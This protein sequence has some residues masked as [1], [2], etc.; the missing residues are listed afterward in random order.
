MTSVSIC[1]D[2]MRMFIFRILGL[3]DGR[4]R[5][6]CELLRISRSL[7][8]RSVTPQ[9]PERAYSYTSS[10]NSI[11]RSVNLNVCTGKVLSD[12]ATVLWAAVMVSVE[13]R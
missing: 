2:V 11:G 3:T 6:P 13:Q 10:R 7:G 1:F 4:T 5:H 12:M 9:V 8:E